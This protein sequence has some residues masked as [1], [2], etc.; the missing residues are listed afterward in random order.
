MKRYRTLFFRLFGCIFYK[1]INLKEYKG[2]IFKPLFF[3]VGEVWWMKPT[4]RSHVKTP[5]LV[6]IKWVTPNYIVTDIP[7][8][9][10]LKIQYLSPEWFY[11]IPRMEY[12]GDTDFNRERVLNQKNLM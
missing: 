4:P 8:H 9:H 12:Y 7:G 2:P 3:E 10:S 5:Y 11:H 1:K 6:L